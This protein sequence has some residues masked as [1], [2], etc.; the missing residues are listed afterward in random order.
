MM[1]AVRRGAG[2]IDADVIS[3]SVIGAGVIDAAVTCTDIEEDQLTRTS[4]VL[5]CYSVTVY[6]A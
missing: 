2:V 3:G 4:T 5:Q 6:S 1:G